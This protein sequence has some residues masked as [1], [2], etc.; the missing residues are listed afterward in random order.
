MVSSDILEYGRLQEVR[1]SYTSESGIEM[2][3]ERHKFDFKNKVELRLTCITIQ[4]S[5]MNINQVLIIGKLSISNEN[6]NSRNI[7]CN[8]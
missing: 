7:I 3:P 1:K 4:R 5:A 8:V 6:K 2:N